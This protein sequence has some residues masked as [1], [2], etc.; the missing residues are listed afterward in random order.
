MTTIRSAGHGTA[1][2]DELTELFRG[3]GITHVVDVRRFPGSRRHPHVG[4]DRMTEW[5]PAAS[6][7]YRWV[8]E[9]GGRRRPDPDSTHVGL[10]NLQFRAYADHM[11]TA[12]FAAAVD[13][14]LGL[15]HAASVL[16]MCSESVWWR[17]HRRLLADHLVLVSGVAVEHLFHD[18]RLADHPV[19]PGARP[20]GDH[21]VYDAVPDEPGDP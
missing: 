17:C 1:T 5:L 8:A 6:I 21:V 12:E 20:A 9:L 13:D 14:L 7:D 11:E 19:T 2:Q 4:R 3:A 18:G 10:R 15:A 16:V